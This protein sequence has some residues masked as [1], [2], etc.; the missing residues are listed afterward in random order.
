MAYGNV[1]APSVSYAEFLEISEK[2]KDIYGDSAGSHN[3]F[4]R[5]KCIGT[6]LT[7]EQSKAIRAGTFDD[8]FIGD[9]WTI[10]GYNWRI[11]HFDYWYRCGDTDCTTHHAVIVPDTPLYTAQMHNTS[12]GA[13]ESGTTANTTE[14]G[15]VGSDMY[16]TNLAKAKTM[17]TTAFGSGHILTHREHLTNAVTNGK[18]SGGTWCD[19]NVELMNENMVYGSHIFAPASD[20]STVPNNYTTSRG[21]LA[22]FHLEPRFIHAN[23]DYWCWLRDVVS[24]MAFAD[25]GHDGVAY[26]HN[27]SVV[28]GVRPACPIY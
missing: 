14:G 3:A 25:V 15:Y 18:P 6:A 7:S 1:N 24:A 5:G 28:A 20:G 13:Y 17:F 19:S 26:Y 11:A 10:N 23:R 9:Y 8:M 2:V 21:Q 22:L 16:K 4:Y 12:S 27:A